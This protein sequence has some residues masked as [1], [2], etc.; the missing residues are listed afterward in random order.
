MSAALTLAEQVRRYQTFVAERPVEYAEEMLGVKLHPKQQEIIRAFADPECK[1][2]AIRSGNAAGKTFILAVLGF[3]Y[4][5]SHCPGYVVYSGSSWDSILRT[6]WP[7]VKSIHSHARVALGGKIMSAEWRRADMW[8]VFCISPDEPE[9]FSGFRTPNGVCVIVDEA[10]SL[11]VDVYDAI[12]GLCSGENSKIVLS[13]NPLHLDGPFHAAF[14]NPDFTTYHIDTRDVVEYGISGLATKD[15]IA[16]RKREWGEGSAQWR[17]RVLGEFPVSNENAL[18]PQEWAKHLKVAERSGGELKL[19]VDV[20]RFGADRTVFL[21]RDDYRVI[22][23]QVTTGNTISETSGLVI[24]KMQ[25]HSIAPENVYIDVIGVG[26]GVVDNL[27]E[28]GHAVNG[29]NFA[30]RAEER[31]KYLNVRA[32]CYWQMR[33]AMDPEQNGDGFR[34]GDWPDLLAEVHLPRYKFSRQGGRTQIEEKDEIKKRLGRS[35]DL[36]D[37]LALTFGPQGSD[38]GIGLI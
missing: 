30:E 13:G 34:I 25:E 16:S 10:S 7:T 19:G 3:Q 37:A 35:P 12:L 33:M 6:V 11:S 32:E 5:D 4:S 38:F 2:M 18:I 8:S 31:A 28:D 23:I 21:I 26:A 14:S 9:N 17:A 22:D 20:A 1:M 36:V 15:W 24:H 27:H 29:V